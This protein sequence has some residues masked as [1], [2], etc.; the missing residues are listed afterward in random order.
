MTE[1]E[2]IAQVL[3]KHNDSP[4]DSY[5]GELVNLACGGVEGLHADGCEVAEVHE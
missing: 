4:I 5:L 1:G 2:W 3:A